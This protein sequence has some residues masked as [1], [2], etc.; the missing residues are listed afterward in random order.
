MKRQPRVIFKA[1]IWQLL[2][3]PNGQNVYTINAARTVLTSA[4]YDAYTRC[5]RI[6]PTSFPLR[7]KWLEPADAPNDSRRD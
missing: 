1:A 6:T 2:Y 7:A 5:Y 4:S 3:S